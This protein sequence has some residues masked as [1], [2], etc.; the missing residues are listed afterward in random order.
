MRAAGRACACSLLAA[1]GAASAAAAATCVRAQQRQQGAGGR[2]GRPLTGQDSQQLQQGAVLWQGD[3]RGWMQG[4]GV[5][6]VEG[7]LRGGSG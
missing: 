5:V 4:Y 2:A 7:R 6:A 3:L 1:R